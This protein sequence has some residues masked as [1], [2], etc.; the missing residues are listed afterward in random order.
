MTVTR[1]DEELTSYGMAFRLAWARIK[2]Q[3]IPPTLRT[4]RMPG[5]SQDLD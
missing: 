4:I 3:Q 5:P 1:S 2:H